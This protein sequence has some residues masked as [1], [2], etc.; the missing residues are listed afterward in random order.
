MELKSYNTI[1]STIYW[2]T[3]TQP[4]KAIVKTHCLLRTAVRLMRDEGR[5][6]EGGR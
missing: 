2:Y 4:L 5:D 6:T 3:W 1:I